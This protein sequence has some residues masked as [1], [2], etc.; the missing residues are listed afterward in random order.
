MRPSSKVPLA[1]DGQDLFILWSNTHYDGMMSGIGTYQGKP[2]WIRATTNILAR[3]RYFRIYSITEAEFDHEKRRQDIF[4]DM[5]GVH[6]QF[7]YVDGVRTRRR[8]EVHV[9]HPQEVISECYRLR[10]PETLT[11]EG[12]IPL[13][14]WDGH[15]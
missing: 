11:T 14:W 7:E 9:R 15:A 10:G 2:C 3:N 6:T 1:K 13:A 5:L 12:R 8:N 4:S